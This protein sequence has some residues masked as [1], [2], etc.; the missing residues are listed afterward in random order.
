MRIVKLNSSLIC[1]TYF[2]ANCL[3]QI[4]GFV[5]RPSRTFRSCSTV[6][7]AVAVT[8]EKTKKFLSWAEAEGDFAVVIFALVTL[9]YR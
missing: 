8:D 1:A 7:C 9:I 5:L 6:S 4:T 2:L 3:T